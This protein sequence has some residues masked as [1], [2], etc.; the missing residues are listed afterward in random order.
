V[1]SFFALKAKGNELIGA[2]YDVSYII[3]EISLN[4]LAPPFS[5]AIT[6]AFIFFSN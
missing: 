3:A 6:R 2:I 4:A 5:K 1:I